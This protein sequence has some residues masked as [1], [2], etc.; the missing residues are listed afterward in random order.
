MG[1]F[2]VPIMMGRSVGKKNSGPC[3]K[4]DG[5]TKSLSQSV[6]MEHGPSLESPLGGEKNLFALVRSRAR[7]KTKNKE[8]TG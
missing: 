8:T 7:Q 4:A 6:V 3:G 1:A 5:A 2:R